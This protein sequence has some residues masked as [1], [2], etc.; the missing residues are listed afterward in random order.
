MKKTT[1]EIVKNLKIKKV[2]PVVNSVLSLVAK[3]LY[4][5]KCG[6]E[7]N[8]SVN[9]DDFKHKPLIIVSNHASRMDY[10]F[11]NYAMKRRRINF[12]AAENEFHRSHLKTVFRLGHVIP[13]KNF[14]PDMTTIKGISRILKKEK[15]GCMC[16]FPCG[17]STATG[18]QQPSANGSGKLL[19]HFGV[20]VLGIRIHGGYFVS[21]KFDVKERYGKVEVELFRLFTPEQLA[22]LT[23]HEI[24]R[25][26]DDALFTDDFAW[27]EKRQHSY[28]C[29]WGYANNLEQLLYKCPK[30]GAEMQMVGSGNE[31][32]CKKCGNGGTLDDKFNLVPFPD[33]TL[34]KNLR[35]WFDNQRRAVRKQVLQP[36]F[37][38]EEHVKIGTMPDYGYI[39]NKKI[40]EI[41]GDGILHLDKTGLS[42]K[43]TRNG[44]SW[45]TFVK[46]EL[47][48]TLCFPVDASFF[49]TY[50]S[51]EFLYFVPD[52]L[53]CTK[54]LLSV[55]E[56]YRTN[57]G[58]WQNYPWFNYDGE[59]YLEGYP[60]KDS[61]LQRQTK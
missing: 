42:F 48:D 17:M 47:I 40:G 14:V 18:A 45:Q 30:C 1:N 12:V 28:K 2:N 10:A 23:E 21:P 59:D 32:K 11:V 15:N 61:H 26:L 7:I 27:N 5:K 24:Q 29:D 44:K 37:C 16:I 22:E 31:I 41:V 13:K 43:G 46:W 58:K 8:R 57:G 55:E 60:L 9:P 51:G 39:P 25:L 49:Y 35:V 53:S 19:K 56:V 20:D 33:S 34:P 3:T 52:T 6:V 54:W 50:A 4:Y 36:N 38:L